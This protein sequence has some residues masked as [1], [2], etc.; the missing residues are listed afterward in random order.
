MG[1]SPAMKLFYW[2]RKEAKVPPR[3]RDIAELERGN[4]NV[5]PDFICFGMQKAGTQW[6]FDQMNARPDVWMPPVKEIQ[7]FTGSCLKPS[8]MKLVESGRGS[9]PLI[10]REGDVLRSSIFLER[11][12][13]LDRASDIEWYRRLFSLK[14]DRISGDVSPAYAKLTSQ[15]ITEV[16]ENFAETRFI[17]FIREPLGRLWSALCMQVRFG[18]L[19][20][21]SLS[22]WKALEPVLTTKFVSKNSYASNVWERWSE[23]VP[24]NRIRYWFFDDIVERPDVVADEV[25]K[26]LGVQTGS[27]ALPASFNRKDG[28]RKIAMPSEIRK[29]LHEFFSDELDRC[30]AI[31]GGHAIRWRDRHD[32]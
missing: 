18:Q 12:V 16:A 11:F 28:N 14:G 22:D 25:F 15:K 7:Y 13:S 29:R 26:Y 27:G 4:G 3:L 17:L 10:P 32:L 8:N 20:E 24:A 19:E 21:A 31:F 6:L 30:A 2:P 9:L 5:G 1:T 23:G